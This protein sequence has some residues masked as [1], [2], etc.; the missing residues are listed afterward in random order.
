MSDLPEYIDEDQICTDEEARLAKRLLELEQE[1]E[2]LRFALSDAIDVVT[3]NRGVY[4]GG[5]FLY[6]P[7]ISRGRLED[8]Q[9][10]LDGGGG[11]DA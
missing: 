2:R 3:Q 11:D 8:W 9:D 7:Q 5:A 10:A 6:C 4:S 1:L